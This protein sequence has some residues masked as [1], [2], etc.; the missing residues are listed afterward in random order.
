MGRRIAVLRKQAGL[1]QEALAEKSNLH[2][3]YIGFIEQGKRD[4]SIGSLNKIA[5]VLGLDVETLFASS[6]FGTLVVQ[7][8]AK[9][10][11]LKKDGEARD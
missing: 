4:P 6:E 9:T 5:R 11:P 8:K 1:S 2:R 7:D 10:S 3:T